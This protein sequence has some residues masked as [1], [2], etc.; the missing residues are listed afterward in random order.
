MWV[1][2]RILRVLAALVLGVVAASLPV[3]GFAAAENYENRKFYG[4]FEGDWFFLF[5]FVAAG[6]CVWTAAQL[7][8]RHS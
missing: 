7:L 4:V 5:G 8:Q 6:A 2:E 3:M 1:V